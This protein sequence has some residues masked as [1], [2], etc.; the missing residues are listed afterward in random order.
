[1]IEE[2]TSP[3]MSDEAIQRGSG[4]TWPEWCQVLDAWGAAEKPHD[5]IARHV[6]ELGVDGWWAQAVTV[7]YER[8]IGRRAVGERADGNFSTSA[9]KTVPAGI[10]EH[11]AAW[12]D[13]R[14][15]DEWLAQG[16]LSLRTAQDGKSA[17]FDDN[18]YGG[19]IGLHF[20]DKGEAKSSV[21]IQIEKLASRDDIPE[22]KATWKTRLD[23]LSAY[24][25]G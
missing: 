6:E 14:R 11:F 10:A 20:T 9:S 24:L 5:E 13:D 21:G 3:Q 4:K 2:T 8:L 22:R 18:E 7:G 16:T 25:K 1:M 17:R 19:I 23:D 15:R 12:V